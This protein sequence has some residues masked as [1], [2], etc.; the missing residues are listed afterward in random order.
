MSWL[1]PAKVGCSDFGSPTTS[2]HSR[3][4]SGI[5]ATFCSTLRRSRPMTVTSAKRSRIRL[6]MKRT[7]FSLRAPTRKWSSMTRR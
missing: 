4:N 6:T 7:S 1:T 5:L 2:D 3:S